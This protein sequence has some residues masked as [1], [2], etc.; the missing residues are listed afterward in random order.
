MKSPARACA[1]GLALAAAAC[2][3]PQEPPLLTLGN[4]ACDGQPSFQGAVL[5]PFDR[6][7]GAAAKL[8]LESR[9]LRLAATA[10]TPYAVFELP[11]AARPYTL[12]VTSIASGGSLVSLR[13]TLY[14][15]AR[16]PVRMLAPEEFRSGITGLRAGIRLRGGERW[17]VA[18]ADH[19]KL[20]Q[21]VMLRLGGLQ[22]GEVQ[23]AA[24]GPVFIYIPPPNVPD[25]VRENSA[26]YSLNGIVNVSALSIPTVP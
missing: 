9:C 3:G 7:N 19:A 11:D 15:A 6:S 8:G 20:G 17:L 12:N 24:A 18:E 5:V 13:V 26:T 10:A 25:I 23:I 22:P 14:D 16:Q 21:P 2:T 4:R 1:A